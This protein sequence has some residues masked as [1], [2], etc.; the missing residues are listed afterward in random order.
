MPAS[1]HSAISGRSRILAGSPAREAAGRPVILIAARWRGSPCSRLPAGRGR[2]RMGRC[3]R[4]LSLPGVARDAGR[5]MARMLDRGD[6]LDKTL[7]DLAALGSERDREQ[8]AALRDRLAAARL[9][10][11]V[12]GGGKRG[13]RTPI[14]ALL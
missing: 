1:P 14:N 7:E 8:L 11:L 13:K 6:V 5:R 3:R 2:P 4:Q 10:V 9:G 12:A